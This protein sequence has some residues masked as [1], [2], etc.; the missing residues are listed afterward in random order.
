MGRRVGYARTDA[1]G[2]DACGVERAAD[3]LHCA[4]IDPSPDTSLWVGLSASPPSN[5]VAFFAAIRRQRGGVFARDDGDVGI[6]FRAV[7]LGGCG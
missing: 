7:V 5:N 6:G 3:A 1:L 4:W 2:G